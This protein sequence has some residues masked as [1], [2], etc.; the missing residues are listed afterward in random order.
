[1]SESTGKTLNLIYAGSGYSGTLNQRRDVL[2]N[3]IAEGIEYAK[4]N[5]RIDG[6]YFFS[7]TGIEKSGK[8]AKNIGTQYSANYWIGTLYDQET[9]KKE[10]DTNVKPEFEEAI[11]KLIN[12]MQK[13][14]VKYIVM[15]R[16]G[17][18]HPVK[19]RTVVLDPNNNFQQ[20][21]PV[22]N[23]ASLRRSAER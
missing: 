20:I 4:K 13:D 18:I 19:A 9:L 17:M 15:S 8:K 12:M 6:F 16:T 3:P 21:Y 2:Q 14:K 22:M 5:E 11:H 7:H 10:L 1:M 23:V